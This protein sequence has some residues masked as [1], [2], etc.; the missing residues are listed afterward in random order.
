MSC[1]FIHH[2]SGF[3]M[4]FNTDGRWCTR[5]VGRHVGDVTSCSLSTQV[6]HVWYYEVEYQTRC[7]CVFK[8]QI[9]TSP[10]CLPTTPVHQWLSVCSSGAWFHIVTSDGTVYRIVTVIVWEVEYQTRCTWVLKEQVATS[11]TC[12]PTSLVHR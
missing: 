8:D 1:T 10:T 5:L 11:P 6:H 12:L 9:V 7:T 2:N 3:F 4:Y